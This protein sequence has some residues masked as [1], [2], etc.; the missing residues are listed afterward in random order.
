MPGSLQRMG[1][2]CRR[3]QGGAALLLT[4]TLLGLLITIFVVILVNDL[5]RENYRRQQTAAALAKAKE[6]LIGYAVSANLS[7]ACTD[8]N[9]NCVRPGDLPCPDLNDNG[10]ADD[11]P[12][13][14]LSGGLQER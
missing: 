13:S 2:Y 8:V 7:V 12:C 1:R 11:G 3:R 5:V 14:N 9:N 6:A 10:E 4:L